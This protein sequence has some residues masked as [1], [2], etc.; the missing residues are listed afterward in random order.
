ME[1]SDT[2]ASQR[3]IGTSQ[4]AQAYRGITDYF[5]GVFLLHVPSTIEVTGLTMMEH[6]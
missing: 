3:Q 1:N 4:K 5:M 2:C 6:F